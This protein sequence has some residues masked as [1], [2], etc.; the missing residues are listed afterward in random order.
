VSA[1]VRGRVMHFVFFLEGSGLALFLYKKAEGKRVLRRVS[2]V[3]GTYARDRE[4]GQVG[5]WLGGRVTGHS[6]GRV[7]E[8]ACSQAGIFFFFSRGRSL[9]LL[10]GSR[11]FQFRGNASACAAERASG[12]G[13]RWAGVRS[14]GRLR[15]LVSR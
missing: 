15:A 1:R 9:S 11:Q 2:E 13:G 3:V 5:G 6:V 12:G 14:G 8:R 4:S 10:E 7:G